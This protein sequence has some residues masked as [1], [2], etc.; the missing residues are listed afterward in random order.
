LDSRLVVGMDIGTTKVCTVVAKINEENDLEI[1]GVGLVP[2]KGLRK[3]VVI[4]IE[5]TASS[6]AASVEKA[7]IQAGMEV[8]GV[9]IGISG[10]HIEGIN[11]KGVIAVS[12]KN[13][14]ISE[15]DVRRVIDAATAIVIPVDREVVHI[16]PQEF[17]VDDQ[18]G[19]KDPVGMSGIRLEAVVNV[20]T[21]AATSVN[22]LVKSLN[23]AGFDA[24]DMVL[25]PLA[26]A[27]AILTEEEKELG[28]TLVDIGG[29]TTDYV[30]FEAG[31]LRKTGIFSIGGNHI[32]NDIA[33][34]LKTPPLAAEDIKRKYGAAIADYVP[35][36]EE[37]EVPGLGGRLPTKE[38][39]RTLVNIIEPRIEEILSLVN[40]EIDKSGKKEMMAAGVVLTG[41]VA[42]TPYIAEL[43]GEVF[44][45][46]VRIGR[47]LGIKGLKD[48]VDSPIF[49]TA[50]GLTLYAK[51]NFP[52]LG[53]TNSK[54]DDKNFKSIIDRM[55]Q[56]FNE[57]F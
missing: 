34:G 23:K 30:M 15:T 43:A 3:G 19:I 11:S 46:P 56:W 51:D 52:R 38:K 21:A 32:T 42:L 35:S 29:G 40:R 28:V 57:F 1:L 16:I 10:G 53:P 26:S 55:R 48:I 33:F 54:D 39:R 31:S 45:L 8:K 6:I 47:P 50:V 49:S 17:I 2:S 5:S 20:I 44:N 9:Y 7:E 13:K 24:A 25:E 41:G 37:I 22:N 36:E 4:N 12:D 27:Q 14:E 18:D